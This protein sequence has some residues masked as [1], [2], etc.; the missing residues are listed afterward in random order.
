METLHEC[1]V[2]LNEYGNDDIHYHIDEWLEDHGIADEVY[3]NMTVKDDSEHHR[4][5]YY[6]RFHDP[7]HAV[8]FKLRFG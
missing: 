8:A 6:Y 3:S 4:R 1:I 2:A 5:D 7:R